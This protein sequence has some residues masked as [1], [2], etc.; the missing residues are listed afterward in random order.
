MENNEKKRKNTPGVYICI[1]A[2]NNE[3]YIGETIKSILDQTYPNIHLIIVDDHS[4]DDTMR[5]LRS[6]AEKD[7][8]VEIYEN[9][10]NLGMSGNWNRCLT[11][12]ME[13]EDCAYIKLVCADDLLVPKAIEKEVR[14]LQKYPGVV[15]V[16]SETKLVD[17][18]GNGKG[19]YSRYP[20]RGPVDGKKVVRRGF[21][22]KD[23]FGAPQANMFRKS[24]CQKAGGFDPALNYIIDYDFFVRLAMCGEV[25]ALHE[26]LNLFRVRKDSNTGQ[27]MGE[28][29]RKTKIY[30]DEHRYLV[31]KQAKELRL[32]NWQVNLSV[33]IRRLRCFMASVYLKIFVRA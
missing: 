8:R 1:P 20:A 6:F 32:A 4:K 5:V 24:A 16:S 7:A 21:F 12:C 23:Y 19:F 27:V 14:V 17:L 30:V 18:K 33:R 15:L 25:Y 11:L 2:Y 9:E 26:S 13:R 22:N 28:D 10:N 31:E 29:K 3:S